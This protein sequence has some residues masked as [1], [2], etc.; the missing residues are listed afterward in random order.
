MAWF[1]GF[2][3]AD[4]PQYAFAAIYEGDIGESSISGGGKVAPMVKTV[5]DRIY[6]MKKDRDEPFYKRDNLLAQTDP[7]KEEGGDEKEGT[8]EEASDGEN[9]DDDA[10]D[11]AEPRRSSQKSRTATAASEAAPDQPADDASDKPARGFF[12]RLF[13]RE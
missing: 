11:S 9:A 12:K 13:S 1:A 7:E 3:P 4:N 10:A 6:K 8:S 5:F 2:L